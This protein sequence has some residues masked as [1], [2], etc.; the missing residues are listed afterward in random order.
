MRQ[1][2]VIGARRGRGRCARSKI[3]ES[4][5]MTVNGGGPVREDRWARRLGDVGDLT[6]VLGAEL[7]GMMV[8][9]VFVGVIEDIFANRTRLW[10]PFR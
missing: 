2:A 6:K 10:T 4:G 8:R 3:L 9:T 1:H 7:F 5:S